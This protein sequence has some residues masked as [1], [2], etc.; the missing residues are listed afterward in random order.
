MS[1]HLISAILRGAWLLDPQYA[2]DHTHIIESILKGDSTIFNNASDKKEDYLIIGAGTIAAGRHAS[3]NNAEPGSIALIN[4]SGPILKYDGDC[5]EPGSMRMAAQIQQADNH[6]NI[7]SIIVKI[8]SPGG[9]VDGTQ[10]LADAIKNTSKPVVGFIED[11]TAAS[12]AYWMASACDY[13][14]ASRKTDMIGSIGVFIQML[15]YRSALDAKGIK[16]IEIYADQ[17]SEKNLPFKEALDG[18]PE[19][20]KKQMLNP[21]ASA[22]ISAVKS[23]RK[24]KLNLEAGDPFKGKIYMA[25]EALKIGLIDEIG[26]FEIAVN[27]ASELASGASANSNNSNIQSHMKITLKNT[28]TGLLAL[29]SVTASAGETTEAD[30]TAE[31]LEAM[32]EKVAGFDALTA[33]NDALKLAATADEKKITDLTAS[34]ASE[35]EKVTE[36][37]GVIAEYGTKPGADS[38]DP[39]KNGTDELPDGPKGDQVVDPEASHN[40]YAEK[41]GL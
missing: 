20:L 17:S 21:I 5:G 10:T 12:A 23:N 25:D 30:I 13:I 24:G 38:Q 32:N 26:A 2:K 31:Q 34:L 16:I 7:S 15:D 19:M 1:F 36:L 9:M 6:P 28:W 22:F 37:E 27:K 4:I 3:F 18:N 14:I 41:L 40:K 35:T 39:K 33:A 29:F 11:G 8:D